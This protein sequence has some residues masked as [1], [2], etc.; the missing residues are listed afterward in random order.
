MCCLACQEGSIEAEGWVTTFVAGC[1]QHA[2]E[3]RCIFGLTASEI[4][5]KTPT[6]LVHKSCI[7][8]MLQQRNRR[9]SV[10]LGSSVHLERDLWVT[11]CNEIICFCLAARLQLG[12]SALIFHQ[13]YVKPDAATS[14]PVVSWHGC[15]QTGMLCCHATCTIVDSVQR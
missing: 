8:A 3:C 6:L 9:R 11:A 12:V 1:R 4:T 5:A 2:V 14:L 7:R 10:W 15:Q 13:R